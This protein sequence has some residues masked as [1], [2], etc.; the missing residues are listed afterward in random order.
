MMSPLLIEVLGTMRS[1]E[2]GPAVPRIA[3]RLAESFVIGSCPG[4]GPT[5]ILEDSTVNRRHAEV[6]AR[7]GNWHIRDLHSDNG[8]VQLRSPTDLG[9]AGPVQGLVGE[10][11]Q[12]QT[13]TT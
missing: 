1:G 10:R 12:E 2:F 8:L 11:V 5:L 7:E 6:F 9:H 4:P 13:I 3:V